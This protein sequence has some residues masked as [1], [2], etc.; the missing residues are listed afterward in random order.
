MKESIQVPD[1]IYDPPDGRPLYPSVCEAYKLSDAPTLNFFGFT[2]L[3]P[4]KPTP[5]GP[6]HII[7]FYPQ[8]TYIQ[9]VQSFE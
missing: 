5:L 9:F 6:E 8:V 7:R 3:Q 2:M 4:E 1:E